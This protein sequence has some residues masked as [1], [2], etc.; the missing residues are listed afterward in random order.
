MEN[1]NQAVPVVQDGELVAMAE[2]PAVLV[3]QD[4]AVVE[5]AAVPYC[6]APPCWPLPVVEAVEVVLV[7]TV[8]ANRHKRLPMSPGMPEAP[9]LI[10]P[11][12][13]AVE[14]VVVAVNEEE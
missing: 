1:Q 2:L 3:Y 12:T 6:E 4:Q 9:E 5:A 8:Q 10:N 14:A 13:A 11:V 7:T